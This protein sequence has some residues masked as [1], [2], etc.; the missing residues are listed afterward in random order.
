VNIDLDPVADLAAAIRELAAVLTR[1][2]GPCPSIWETDLLGTTTWRSCQYTAGHTGL[3]ANDE[4]GEARWTDGAPGVR[5]LGEDDKGCTHCNA[6]ERIA[7]DY[8]CVLLPDH[9]GDHR[10]R[11]GDTW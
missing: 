11:D 10:D 6:T 7:P 3:H 5:N 4:K 9:V 1:Q 2:N 8:P